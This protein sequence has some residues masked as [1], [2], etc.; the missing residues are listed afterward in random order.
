MDDFIE[1]LKDKCNF[2]IYEQNILD[3]Y[4]LSSY[5]KKRTATLEINKI[6]NGESLLY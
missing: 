2:S 6:I 4:V 3:E 1:F 5:E